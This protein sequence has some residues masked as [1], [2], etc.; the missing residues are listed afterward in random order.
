[1]QLPQSYWSHAHIKVPSNRGKEVKTVIPLQGQKCSAASHVLNTRNARMKSMLQW[2]ISLMITILVLS[3]TEVIFLLVTITVLWFGFSTGIGIRRMLIIYWCFSCCWKIKAFSTSRVLLMRT[4]TRSWEEAQSE[5]LTQ[6]GQLECSISQNIMLSIE[7]RVDWEA[8]A[9]S[10]LGVQFHNFLSSKIT[11]WKKAGHWSASGEQLYCA[12]LICVFYYCYHYIFL[13]FSIITL[14]LSQ[15][16]PL[17]LS[18]PFPG[19]RLSEQ[20]AVWCL[21]A[22]WVQT[23]TLTFIHWEWIICVRRYVILYNET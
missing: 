5:Q 2:N 13:F 3:R 1:M 15:P 8:G 18:F 16:F 23:V 7:M 10:L 21:A 20:T 19:A 14:F 4:C 17:Q 12:S 22:E 6:T 11:S 9:L